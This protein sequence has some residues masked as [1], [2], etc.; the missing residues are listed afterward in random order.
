MSNKVGRPKNIETPEE[1]WKLFLKFLKWIEAN[2][3]I[4]KVVHNKTGEIIDLEKQRPLTWARFDTWVFDQDIISDLEDY[5]QNREGRYSEFGGI[6]SRIRNIMYANKF[7]G[8]SVNIFNANIIARDLG[9]KDHTSNE[10]QDKRKTIAE[11]FPD[12]DEKSKS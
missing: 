12:F 8:A 7:E 11:L 9:L 4:E 6:I 10:I 2:P 5:R 3:I 1:L